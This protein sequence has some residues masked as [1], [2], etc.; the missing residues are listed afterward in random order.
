[1][2]GCAGARKPRARWAAARGDWLNAE[3]PPLGASATRSVGLVCGFVSF[4]RRWARCGARTL[5]GSHA[6][7]ELSIVVCE[8]EGAGDRGRGRGR[9]RVQVPQ[10]DRRAGPNA[11]SLLL[12]HGEPVRGG[13]DLKGPESGDLEGTRVLARRQGKA[14]RAE[15]RACAIGGVGF[16]ALWC[17]LFLLAGARRV[18]RSRRARG[19]LQPRSR[20]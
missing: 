4:W 15:T 2:A 8:S 16:G 18:G 6:R 3:A 5:C 19:S 12:S 11:G 17:S 1:M 14:G 7:W 20:G 9:G 10:R 13:D